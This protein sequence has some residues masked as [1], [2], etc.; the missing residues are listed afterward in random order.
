MEK[1][2]Q[3]LLVPDPWG[4]QSEES[5]HTFVLRAIFG[6]VAAFGAL[7]RRCISFAQFA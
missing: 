2:W 7:L 4:Q 6:M 5:L 1:H 3:F